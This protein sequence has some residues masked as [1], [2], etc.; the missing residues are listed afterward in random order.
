MAGLKKRVSRSDG[1][2]WL[3]EGEWVTPPMRGFSEQ[4]C[5]CGLVHRVDFRVREGKVEFRVYRDGRAT[6]AARRSIKRRKGDVMG[7]A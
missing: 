1:Y 3:M 7:D 4:C 6:A 5:D 2:V